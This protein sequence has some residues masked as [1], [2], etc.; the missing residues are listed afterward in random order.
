MRLVGAVLLLAMAGA[1]ASNSTKPSAAPRSTTAVPPTTTTVVVTS[2]VPT[3][4]TTVPAA[5]EPEPSAAAITTELGQVETAV[6]DPAIAAADLVRL[7]ERQQVLYRTLSHLDA[8]AASA[9]IALVPAAVRP[10]VEL[11]ARAV[12]EL[13]AI[14]VNLRD[15]PP[16]WRIVAPLPAAELLADYKDAGAAEGVPW[17]VLGSIHLIET[18]LG[19]IRGTSTAG[20]QGPMQFLPSTWARYG[21]GGDIE[22]TVDSLHA[23]G[24]L[25]R[26]SGAPGNLDAALF[27]Y[28]HSSH[29]VAAVRAIATV[30]DRD[31]RAFLAYHAWKVIYRTT[32]GDVVLEEGYGS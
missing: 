12:R 26:A 31:E 24:R 8:A 3:T 21:G 9:A 4:T 18:R 13:A 11:N 32:H 29:Y 27:A 22:S 25:L 2:A 17:S 5:P 30:L 15:S 7:G 19:R 1:C 10:A 23:A 28:N 6:R 16:P 20:A 14:P